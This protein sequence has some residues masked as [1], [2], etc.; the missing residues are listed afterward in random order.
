MCE[1][2][3]EHFELLIRNR[4]SSEAQDTPEPGAHYPASIDSVFVLE[5]GFDVKAFSKYKEA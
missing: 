5:K 4:D 1:P 2:L 3:A